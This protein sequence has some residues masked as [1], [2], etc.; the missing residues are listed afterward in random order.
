MTDNSVYN[1]TITEAAKILDKSD[2]QVRRYVKERKLKAKSMRVGGY[3]RL[4]F[5]KDEVIAFRDGS[6]NPAEAN[7]QQTI[8]GQDVDIMTAADSVEDV[9]EEAKPNVYDGQAV[10]Y[11]MD[12]LKEQI[13][14]LRKENQELQTRLERQSGATGFWQ[15]KAEALQV[16]L[17]ALMPIP[18]TEAEESEAVNAEAPKPKKSWWRWFWGLD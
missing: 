10:K 18:K 15:G 4:M 17:K 7:V 12:I 9:K 8:E 14:N 1:I 2:R 13:D 3:V 11:A 16:E 6:S 5:N